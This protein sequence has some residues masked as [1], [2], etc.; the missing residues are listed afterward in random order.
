MNEFPHNPPNR[1]WWAIRYNKAGNV[2]YKTPAY[3]VR[4]SAEDNMRQNY[5]GKPF[6]SGYGECGPDFS[7]QYLK[8]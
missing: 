2:V 5:P 1:K 8:R 7:I 4:E 6:S 3:N